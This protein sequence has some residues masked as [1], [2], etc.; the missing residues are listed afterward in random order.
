[1]G[2]SLSLRDK[3]RACEGAGEAISSTWEGIAPPLVPSRAQDKPGCDTIN[4]CNKIYYI[5]Y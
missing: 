2:G 4:E 1:M 5:Y 3:F